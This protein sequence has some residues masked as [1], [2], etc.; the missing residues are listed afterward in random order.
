MTGRAQPN[1]PSPAS[2]EHDDLLKSVM[3]SQ[4]QHAI[5]SLNET[6]H[7]RQKLEAMGHAGDPLLRAVEAELAARDAMWKAFTSFA[8]YSPAAVALSTY[9]H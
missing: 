5:R 4:L 7:E 1:R 6:R 9:S 8:G 3:R 2:G